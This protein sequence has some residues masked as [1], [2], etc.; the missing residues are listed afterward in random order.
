MTTEKRTHFINQDL[1]IMESFEIKDLLTVKGKPGLWKL[2]KYVPA[3][4]MAR[5]QNLNDESMFATTNLKDIVALK[6]YRIFLKDGKEIVLETIFESMMTMCVAGD[7]KK[8]DLDSYETMSEE[9][10]TKMMDK[11]VPNYDEA[12]FKSYHLSKIIKWYKEIDKAL[13]V[14]AAENPEPT[15]EE[16]EENE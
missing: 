14:F 13:E 4:K 11:I 16:T 5:V 1:K 15:P 7:L 2:V 3:A 6:N 8:E 12:Q 9:D 10:K